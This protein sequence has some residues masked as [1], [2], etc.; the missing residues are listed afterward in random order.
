MLKTIEV[1]RKRKRCFLTIGPEHGTNPCAITIRLR[2]LYIR[3]I[4]CRMGQTGYRSS[5]RIIYRSR[6]CR[7]TCIRIFLRFSEDAYIPLGSLSL[8]CPSK[9]CSGCGERSILQIY[10]RS[11]RYRIGF[12]T[13][14]EIVNRHIVILRRILVE[15]NI[16][17]AT[18]IFGHIYYKVFSSF[19][20]FTTYCSYLGNFGKLVRC[21]DISRA[22][23]H[24]YLQYTI[25]LVIHTC[26]V[27]RT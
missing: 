17:T 11:C 4:L 14:V 7:F 12:G 16:F 18:R 13:Y 24:T 6:E 23:N 20:L 22:T 19:R 27:G 5:R 3:I 10:N 8:L 21:V 25:I 9:G 26:I 2:G 1:C 15:D